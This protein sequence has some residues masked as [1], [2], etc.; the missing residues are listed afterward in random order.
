MRRHCVPLLAAFLIAAPAWAL[1][2]FPSSFHTQ[3]IA[4]N[5]TTLHV[6]IGG[7]GPAVIMLHGFG[8][9]GDMWAPTAAVLVKHH[10]VVVPDLRGMGLS[11]HPQTGYTKK[12]RLW[13][14]QA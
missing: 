9:T 6:R 3:E 8:D 11:A 10:M 13:I 1:E 2:P 4:T 12:T 14:S 7:A 5:G